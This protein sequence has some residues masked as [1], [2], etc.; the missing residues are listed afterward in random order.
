MLKLPNYRAGGAQIEEA[1]AS[2][3][4]THE[5]RGSTL[6]A[7]PPPEQ[8]LRLKRPLET[9]L[10]SNQTRFKQFGPDILLSSIWSDRVLITINN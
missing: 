9:D 10:I 4:G 5:G 2:G 7:R 6:Y 1:R 3:K 8:V